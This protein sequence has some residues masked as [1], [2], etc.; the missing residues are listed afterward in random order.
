V[1]QVYVSANGGNRVKAVLEQLGDDTAHWK[2]YLS[3]LKFGETNSIKV[4]ATSDEDIATEEV[5]E[6]LLEPYVESSYDEL[7][8]LI[9]RRNSLTGESIEYSWDSI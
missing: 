7:G 2:A 1:R 4:T 8:N 6:R 9:S 5:F 3:G